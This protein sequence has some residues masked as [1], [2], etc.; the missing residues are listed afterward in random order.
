MNE[1][2]KWV[3]VIVSAIVILGIPVLFTL[4]FVFSW[5]GVVFIILCLLT[6][7]DVIVLPIGL[8]VFAKYFDNNMEEQSNGQIN[9]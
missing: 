7:A 1:L 5:V 8:Y 4:S 6:I 3:G 2:F 9:Q